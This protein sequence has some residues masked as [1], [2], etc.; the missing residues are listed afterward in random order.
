MS[1]ADGAAPA[2]VV[3]P[4]VTECVVHTWSSW[5]QHAVCAQLCASN[6]RQ[7]S[8][9]GLGLPANLHLKRE[10]IGVLQRLFA[11]VLAAGTASAAAACRR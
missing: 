3:G 8:L 6:E 5:Q 4:I 9:G 1:C 2:A 10:S 11:A 7:G